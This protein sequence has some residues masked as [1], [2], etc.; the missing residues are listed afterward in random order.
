MP[1]K[2]KTIRQNGWLLIL[3]TSEARM[4]LE[5]QGLSLEVFLSIYLI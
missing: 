3:S 4:A 1:K 5:K 2:R